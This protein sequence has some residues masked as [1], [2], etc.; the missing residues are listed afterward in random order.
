MTFIFDSA[1]GRDNAGRVVAMMPN[2]NFAAASIFQLEGWGGFNLFKSVITSVNLAG[3]TNHQVQHTLGERIFLYVFGDRIGSL[4]IGGLAFYD[5]C[6]AQAGQKIGMSNVIDYFNKAKLSQRAAP[7][8]ITLDS[9]SAFEAYLHTL[10]GSLV[11]GFGTQSRL[12]QFSLSLLVPPNS[13][14]IRRP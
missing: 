12:Y 10:R 4:E 13:G 2:A 1:D 6:G 7:L 8:K 3:T 11:S 14:V 5:N 9:S